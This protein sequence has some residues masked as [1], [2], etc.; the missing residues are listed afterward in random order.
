MTWNDLPWNPPPRTLRQFALLWILFFGWLAYSPMSRGTEDGWR[1]VLLFAVL[2][3]SVGIPGVLRPAFLRPIFVG[4]MVLVFPP[5]YIVSRILLAGVFYGLFT[6]LGLL[7]RITGRDAL[8]HRLDR[9][10]ASYWK[11]KPKVTDDVRGYFS[12]F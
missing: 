6:P 11:I 9:G 8:Q 5:G 4:W 7:F 2:A 10:E 1:S 12:Q 3:A